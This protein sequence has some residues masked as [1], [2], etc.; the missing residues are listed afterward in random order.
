MLCIVAVHY[1]H[2][3]TCYVLLLLL[4]YITHNQ[5]MLCIVAVHYTHINT[6][7]VLLLLLLYITH[8]STHATCTVDCT[9]TGSATASFKDLVHFTG[10]HYSRYFG[11]G[12]ANASFWTWKQFTR[13]ENCTNKTPELSVRH[14]SWYEWSPEVVHRRYLPLSPVVFCVFFCITGRRNG[15]IV[16]VH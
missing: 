14:S 4:L 16:D 13:S 10:E 2:I 11:R 12:L 3:N 5:H 6:C 8:I 1:T 15:V 7:Y 9:H